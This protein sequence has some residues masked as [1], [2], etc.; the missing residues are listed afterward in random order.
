MDCVKILSEFFNFL[1]L[2]NSL[3]IEVT[4]EPF[5]HSEISRADLEI[6]ED[7]KKCVAKSYF[8]KSK[9]NFTKEIKA[10]KS[11]IE[12][13]HVKSEIICKICKKK[14]IHREILHFHEKNFH[15]EDTFSFPETPNEDIRSS[16]NQELVSENQ[17][18]FCCI[19]CNL[20]FPTKSILTTT[21]SV[22]KS[23]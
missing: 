10:G 16:K 14:F 12:K 17:D 19:G 7:L 22:K 13:H 1:S 20:C 6:L 9:D 21:Q 2:K 5:D 3:K 4:F 15:T 18:L 11:E 8:S 23:L